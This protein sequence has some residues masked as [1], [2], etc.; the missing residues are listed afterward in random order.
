MSDPQ[1]EIGIQ[2]NKKTFWPEGF[3]ET[4]YHPEGK[5]K[6]QKGLIIMIQQSIFQGAVLEL[7][8]PSEFGKYN[9]EEL[10]VK[11]RPWEFVSVAHVA[12]GRCKG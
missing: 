8:S 12:G 7:M 5:T 4:G 1:K 11:V 6:S 10:S 3:G 9:Q 2:R